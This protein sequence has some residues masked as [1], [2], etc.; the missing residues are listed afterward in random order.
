MPAHTAY[1]PPTAAP[2]LCISCGPTTQKWAQGR[3]GLC[4]QCFTREHGYVSNSEREAERL[5]E[6]R[7]DRARLSV[8]LPAPRRE[9]GSLVPKR[10]VCINGQWFD[11]MY[12]GT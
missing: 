1:A 7:E 10:E 3:H 4:R 9:D 8:R 11:V 6:L 2:R 12:D 5:R